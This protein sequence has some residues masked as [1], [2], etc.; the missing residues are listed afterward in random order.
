MA[1]PW[2]TKDA[3]TSRFQNPLEDE[4]CR[5]FVLPALKEQAGWHDDQ[6]RPQYP[7][8]RGRIK[9]TARR[10]R[11]ER[12]LIADYVLEYSD[13]L[14]I[15][16]IE[17]K[18]SRRDLADGFEQVKRYAELLDVPFAYSTNGHR[19]LELDAR[20]GRLD[21]IDRFPSPQELWARYR[22]DRDLTDPT[23]DTLASAPLSPAVRNWDGSYKEPRYYQQ[24]AINR[25]VQAIARGDKRI[26]LVLAT[27]TGKT[28]VASQIVAKLWNA[29]WPG[30][31]RPRVLYL[32]DRNILIDQPKDDYFEPIFGEAVHRLGGGEAK[33]GRFI[34]LGCTSHW[35]AATATRASTGS[36]LP[37]TS[38][39]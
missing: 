2:S 36:S 10:H 3:V 37:T 15:A 34:Y 11:Q 32:A 30:K 26:L 28:L 20:T 12:P 18:R 17:A 16:V 22:E 19:I 29:N 6:I 39:L 31:R 35:T 24:V 9:A 33:R 1:A 25:T 23:R 5:R 7:I 4:T 27:G 38:T 14:P 8:N 13:G 21:E